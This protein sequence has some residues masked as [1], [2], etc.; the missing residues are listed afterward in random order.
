MPDKAGTTATMANRDGD[1]DLD[2][3]R[4]HYQ[5]YGGGKHALLMLPGVVGTAET[6][7]FLQVNGTKETGLNLQKYQLVV[8]ELPGWGRSRPSEREYYRE[9][10]VFEADARYAME[11]MKHLGHKTFS[12]LG[13]SEGSK[14]ALLMAVLYPNIVLSVVSVATVI[15][16]TPATLFAL[17]STANIKHWPEDRLERYLAIYSF[18]EL[19]TIYR[20]YTKMAEDCM[21][22]GHKFGL[23]VQAG[24]EKRFFCHPRLIDG[25]QD[26]RCPVLIC[27]G[28]VFNFFVDFLNQFYPL[29]EHDHLAKSEQSKYCHQLIAGSE[30]K[31]F[32]DAGH[33]M[34][35][36]H[37]EEFKRSVEQFLDSADDW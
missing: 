29:A 33:N 3:Q 20:T 13:W 30:I 36:S 1:F 10:N 8:M 5:V 7:Y 25:V 27:Y 16:L 17:L 21:E 4:V 32:K 19:E 6:D 22:N 28:M 2:G 34:H 31:C 26:I 24:K 37:P 18:E 15:Y 14:I 11:L 9:D 12:V 35:Q 23:L